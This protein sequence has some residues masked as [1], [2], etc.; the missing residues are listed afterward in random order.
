M[1]ACMHVFMY[2]CMYVCMHARMH[3][4]MHACCYLCMHV[5]MSVCM[6]AFCNHQIRRIRRF[7]SRHPLLHQAGHGLLVGWVKGLGQ[8]KLRATCLLK[9]TFN[10]LCNIPNMFPS[11]MWFV[12]SP[13]YTPFAIIRKCESYLNTFYNHRIRRFLSTHPLQS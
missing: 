2:V 11:R 3:A 4:C 10:M 13:F 5:C 9:F 8:E 12:C 7:L 1:Y 6:Y